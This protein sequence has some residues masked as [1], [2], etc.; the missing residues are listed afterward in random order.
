[1]SL[2][3]KDVSKQFGNNVV[4][5]NY[6]MEVAPGEITVILGESGSGKTTLLRMINHLEEVDKGSI[7]I[8]DTYLVKDGE[9]QDN[10]SIK[11]YQYK[12]GLVFQD[13]QLF[14]NLSVTENLLLAPLSN[15]FADKAVLEERAASLLEQMGV[16]D[17]G[18]SKPSQLSGG[19]KQRVAIAR[20]MMMNPS[21]LCFD[22]PTSALDEKTVGKIAELITQLS[23]QG[24]MILIITHDNE[25]VKLLGDA[26]VI[27]TTEFIK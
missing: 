21:L 27:R 1:M 6:S 10:Q 20:A 18:D 3:V 17:K 25:L 2:I 12:I 5:S 4:I 23:N 24:I 9:Y 16:G 26:R 15:K 7:S 14:P 13:Y 11:D 22:E 8:D 19:Q